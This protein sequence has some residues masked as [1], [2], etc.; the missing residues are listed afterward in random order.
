MTHTILSSSNGCNDLR[1]QMLSFACHPPRT[2]HF[3]ETPPLHAHLADSRSVKSIFSALLV[4]TVVL[5][6]VFF[7]QNLGTSA[8]QRHRSTAK[9]Q[10][11]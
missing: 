11:L 8:R 1:V 5:R 10:R 2:W 7:S 4:L 9:I 6:L 3:E